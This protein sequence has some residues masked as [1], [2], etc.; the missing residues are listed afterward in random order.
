MKKID[1]NLF[2]YLTILVVSWIIIIYYL[3]KYPSDSFIIEQQ[4]TYPYNHS[5]I[6][7]STLNN[8]K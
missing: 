5:K 1:K 7:D 8:G 2:I 4:K 6:T 3:I